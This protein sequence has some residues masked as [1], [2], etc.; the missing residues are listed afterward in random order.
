MCLRNS[1]LHKDLGSLTAGCWDQGQLTSPMS[2]PARNFTPTTFKAQDDSEEKQ[3]CL[4]IQFKCSLMATQ[5]VKIYLPFPFASYSETENSSKS[6]PV[7]GTFSSSLE[8]RLPQQQCSPLQNTY[9]Q[10]INYFLQCI[11]YFTNGIPINQ[12]QI[13]VNLL[14]TDSDSLSQH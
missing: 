4:E 12:Q 7:S 10:V 11:S 1:A 3:L 6:N 9:I 5:V 13:V 8:H 2:P 14:L